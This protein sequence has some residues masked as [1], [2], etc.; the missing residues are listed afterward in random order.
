MRE[1]NRNET[2][3]RV[4][5]LR[6]MDDLF[7]RRLFKDDPR[8]TEQVLRIIMDMP[9][10]RVSEVRTQHEI[11]LRP[12]GVR[13][14]CLDV[15]AEDSEGRLYN[16]EIQRDDR[17]A[18]P[19]RARHNLS[20]IDAVSLKKGESVSELPEVY[21][22]FITEHDIYRAGEAVYLFEFRN[23]KTG[24]PFGDGAHIMYVNGEYRGADPLGDLMHDFNCADPHRMRLSF[25]VEKTGY[26]KTNEEGVTEMCK[27]IDDYA[28]EFAEE[29]AK[30]VVMNNALNMIKMGKFTHADIAL[31]L[32]IPMEEVTALAKSLS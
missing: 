5:R 22:I 11:D 32:G 24:E 27:L 15:L 20:A 18:A 28:R 7:M 6:P 31:G 1:P 29:Y 25:M 19:K 23:V 4:A 26:Y 9:D 21:V 10:L 3:K 16:I 2:R 12:I 8:L 14:L 30:D 13:S 17:G